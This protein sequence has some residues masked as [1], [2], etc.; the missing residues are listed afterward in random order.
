MNPPQSNKPVDENNPSNALF[1]DTHAHLESEQF[2]G[3]QNHI[4]TTAQQ[5]G[6]QKVIAVGCSWGSSQ[7]SLF[8]ANQHPDVYAAVGIHPNY[9]QT[10]TPRDWDRILAM[11]DHPKVV[12]LGETGLDRYWDYTPFDVQQEYF[13]RHIQMS[14]K[15]GLPLVI[16][17]REC[18]QD[19]LD[20]L[21]SA[22][23]KG[24]LHGVM[25]SFVGDLN[26]A[27]ACLDLGL[28]ISFSGMV[29]FKKNDALREIAAAIP[30]DRILLET[31]C[32]YLT[33][34]PYRSQRPNHP[35]MMLHTAQCVA[36][37]RQTTLSDL[38]A[39]T[40]RNACQ[41]FTRLES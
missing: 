31:D 6:V 4:L 17:M 33:P 2:D 1:I 16:H 11:L 37:V 14:Q 20:M 28:Y 25:H 22:R 3:I 5:A 15:T 23:Q 10:A 21:T 34:H 38:A 9:C 12:A 27:R 30:A 39:E 41:L 7:K 19:I 32:P 13:N 29:T 40:S 8:L 24:P 35:A 18:E 36:Q 26:T